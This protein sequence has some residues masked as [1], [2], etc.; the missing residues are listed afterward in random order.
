[1]KDNPRDDMVATENDD[2]DRSEGFHFAP[3][4]QISN[5]SPPHRPG[6]LTSEVQRTVVPLKSWLSNFSTA[7]FR[8]AAVSNSTNLYEKVRP[9]HANLRNQIP[10]LC[11]RG[12][13]QP[14]NR[15]RQ[16]RSGGQN[17]SGPMVQVS[18]SPVPEQN[19]AMVK[20]GWARHV[21][22]LPER[23]NPCA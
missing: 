1:L 4:F 13:G 11:H 14:R 6:T 20:E 3:G 21:L 8:S 23:D 5:V 22:P 12:H 18:P 16:G 9:V 2:D 10:T 17:L 19:P 7:T 15:P